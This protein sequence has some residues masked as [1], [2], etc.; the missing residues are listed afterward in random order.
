MDKGKRPRI[1]LSSDREVHY[2]HSNPAVV[3]TYDQINSIVQ[4]VNV[5]FDHRAGIDGCLHRIS[6][7]PNRNEETRYIGATL[8]VGRHITGNIEPP[9]DL[10]SSDPRKAPSLLVLGPPGTGKTTIIR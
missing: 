3:V 5:G 6:V 10:L 4:K 2:L 7:I 8:R 9:R 1:K